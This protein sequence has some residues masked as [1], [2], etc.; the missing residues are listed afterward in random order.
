MRICVTGGAGFIGVHLCRK[1]LAQGHYVI[2]ADI[3]K[4]E[5]FSDSEFCSEFIL[6]DLRNIEDCLKVTQNCERV[7]NLAADMGGMGYIQCNNSRILYN[8]MQISFHVLEACR[9]NG[10]KRILYTSSACVYP[11]GK[12]TAPDNPGLKET[13]A[14]PAKPQDAYG[15][16]KLV[17]EELYMYY[18][19]DYMWPE[20]RIARLHNIYGPYGA[21]KGGRE[22]APAAFC[23]KIAVCAQEDSVKMWGDG[24]QTRTFCYIDDCIEGL[25][26]LMDSSYRFPMNIGSTELISMN[27]MHSLICSF[28]GKKIDVKHIPGP[29]GVKGR[30][31]DNTLVSIILGWTPKTPLKEGLRKLY[32][33]IKQE[34]T[35]EKEKDFESL[36][37][38]K[39]L[40]QRVS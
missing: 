35:K 25:L 36:K 30:C 20:T 15:L 6:C 21:W 10:V 16:E 31:S 11:E 7:F 29:E 12:Q 4:N 38:S 1:L 19:E 33:W 9:K 34:L 8:N 2:A 3:R 37:D 40:K 13:E 28:E 23:R 27:D 39:V 18:Q 5:Y 14:W 24:Q 26:K 22:K 17:S 32:E